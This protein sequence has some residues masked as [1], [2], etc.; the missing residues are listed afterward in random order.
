MPERAS[1]DPDV[2]VAPATAPGGAQ[3]AVVRLSG[4][5]CAQTASSVLQSAAWAHATPLNAARAHTTTLIAAGAHAGAVGDAAARSGASERTEA[6]SHAAQRTEA[7]PD[8]TRHGEARSGTAGR[9]GAPSSADRASAAPSATAGNASLPIVAW[10][11]RGP[12]SYTGE[13]M[14]ELHMPGS[15]ALVADVVARLVAAGARPAD[16]GEF[17]LRAV[18]NGR[19][20]LVAAEAVAAR[21]AARSDGQLRAATELAAGTLTRTVAALNDAL[22]DVLAELEAALD[23]ADEPIEFISAARAADRLAAARGRLADL[24]ARAGDFE[25]LEHRPTVVLVGPPNAGKST[26]T[27]R[28]TGLERAL[29]SPVAGTTRDV[30][31]APLALPGGEV[32]LLDGAGLSPDVPADPLDALARRAAESAVALADA[33]VLV[34][35]ATADPRAQ[36]A[37]TRPLPPGRPI[38]R[39][40][41]KCDLLGD[42]AQPLP[43]GGGESDEFGRESDVAQPPATVNSTGRATGPEE[44]TA[45]GGS[46][47]FMRISALTGQGVDRLRAALDRAVF[48][49]ESARPAEGLMLN[50]RHRAALSAAGSALERAIAL[51]ADAGVPELLAHELREAIDRL[52]EISGRVLT[53]DILSRIFS[54]FCVGK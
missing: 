1:G 40:L 36:Y 12:R 19:I 46:A 52:G 33:V 30:L 44:D 42:S 24:V 32:R 41:N 51:A 10:V 2:I 21:I 5:G 28:L 39:V 4:A 37:L 11:F 38:V 34:L 8:V 13:D 18:L 31:S 35:D 50:A 6:R 16:P 20:D 26:L 23:F 48:A 17:T 45:G 29:C 22:A 14:V 49:D 15:P 53:D 47:T 3:R 25:Q 54:K 27:N 9:T 7:H 43:L